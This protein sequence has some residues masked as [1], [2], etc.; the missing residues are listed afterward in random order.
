M[1]QNK[2]T[3]FTLIEIM[4][5]MFIIAVMCGFGYAGLNNTIKQSGKIEQLREQLENLQLTM[6][7]LQQDLTQ[8]VYRNIINEYGSEEHALLAEEN[9]TELL[10]LTRL[11]WANPA[12][13][14]RSSMTRVEWLID[15]DSNL[16]RRHWYEL[17]RAPGAEPVDTVLL[18]DIESVEMKFLDQN[19]SWQPIWPNIN[20]LGA[21]GALPTIPK[22]ADITFV[23]KRW[24]EVRRVFHLVEVVQPPLVNFSGGP[25]TP[26]Q[27]GRPGQRP[28]GGGPGNDGNENENE[29]ESDDEESDDDDFGAER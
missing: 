11:G 5:V 13:Q 17:D 7:L 28:G 27:N 22:V 24:G 8:T 1:R 21:G 6:S 18:E 14:A 9:S 23:T 2:Q 20:N 16:V 3:G 26:G 15:D 10:K 19:N 29:E 25:G 4:V 12:G